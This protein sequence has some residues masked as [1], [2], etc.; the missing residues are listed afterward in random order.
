MTSFRN[1]IRW[2]AVLLLT[3]L[4]SIFGAVLYA[5]LSMLLYGQID[6][7]LLLLANAEVIH[8]D[9][10]TGHLKLKRGD[11]A[12]DS[13]DDEENEHGIEEDLNEFEEHELRES[14][15]S[16]LVM[17]PDGT[18]LW[19]GG[20]V[21]STE[22]LETYRLAQ[23]QRGGVAY[24]TVTQGTL[25]P[26]RRVFVPITEHGEVKYILQTERSLEFVKQA[27]NWLLVVLI[28]GG[29]AVIGMAWIASN[30]IAREA[31]TPVT[32][33]SETAEQISERTLGTRLALPAPY[34]EFQ[35]LADS[36]NRMLDR[37]ERVFDAQRLFIA[38]A[39][40]ELRTPQTVIRGTLEVALQKART[41][42]EYREAIVTALNA[43]ERLITLNQSLLVLA[44]YASDRPPIT[45]VPLSLTPVVQEVLQEVTILADDQ[46]ISLTSTLHSIPLIMGDAGQL[47]RVL[48][49]L[50]DNALRHTPSGGN[51]TVRLERRGDTVAIDVQDTGPGIPPEHIAH[52]FER[53]YRADQSRARDS[54]GAGLGLAIAYEIVTAHHGHIHVK[55]EM[56]EGST[57]TISFPTSGEVDTPTQAT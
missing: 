6:R 26:I 31:L 44:Q 47:R 25:S 48:I 55:S 16:S 40:H 9:L 34:I 18:V 2:L 20:T 53:F 5:G 50:L 45:L 29:S 10:S 39:A 22:P 7:K 13:E 52:V 15:R 11:R 12:D 24:D 56:G 57:F 1:R 23:V 28:G 43:I 38:D 37:L 42:E 14:T 3:L 4:L 17:T 8:V 54:G 32:S 51:V 30:W 41:A 36:F 21:F 49:N 27:L 19:E 35:R 33:L 46:H